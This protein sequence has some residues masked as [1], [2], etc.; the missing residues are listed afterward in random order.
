MIRV[1]N[2]HKTYPTRFG[3]KEVLTDI[4]FE[5]RKGEKLGILG[6]NGAGKSTLIRLISGAEFPTKGRVRAPSSKSKAT[7]LPV[8]SLSTAEKS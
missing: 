6:R 7:S 8:S 5:L 4:N 3:E 1:E 2:L